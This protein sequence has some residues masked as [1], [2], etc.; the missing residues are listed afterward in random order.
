[1]FFFFNT[2]T[3]YLTEIVYEQIQNQY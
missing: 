3:E 2:G 1:L